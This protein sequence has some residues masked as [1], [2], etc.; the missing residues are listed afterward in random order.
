MSYEYVENECVKNRLAV[1][2]H[3]CMRSFSLAARFLLVSFFFLFFVLYFVPS[4]IQLH[5]EL[6]QKAEN[7]SLI[8]WRF[9]HMYRTI[10]LFV[11]LSV[12]LFVCLYTC[13]LNVACFPLVWLSLSFFLSEWWCNFTGLLAGSSTKNLRQKQ[14]SKNKP[15]RNGY[16]CFKEEDI[17]AFLWLQLTHQPSY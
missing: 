17:M 15:G 14:C 6:T 5:W 10:V 4:N 13:I 16:S 9:I 8:D 2:K 3:I 7:F 11:C 1:Q 12:W